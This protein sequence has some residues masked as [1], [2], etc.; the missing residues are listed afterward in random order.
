MGTDSVADHVMTAPKLDAE[1]AVRMLRNLS[2]LAYLVLLGIEH[3]A[4]HSLPRD[5]L[6]ERAGWALYDALEA[7]AAQIEGAA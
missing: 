3:H 1:D 4:E 7:F 2:A 6:Y 5:Q